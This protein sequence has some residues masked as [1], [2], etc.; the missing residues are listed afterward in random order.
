MPRL[1]RSLLFFSLSFVLLWSTASAASPPKPKPAR[2]YSAPR[3]TGKIMQPSPFPGPGGPPILTIDGDWKLIDVPAGLTVTAQDTSPPVTTS[4]DQHVYVLSGADGVLASPLP[5]TIKN[6]LVPSSDG[7]IGIDDGGDGTAVYMVSQEVAEGIDASEAAGEL[8]PEIAAIAEPLDEDAT[9]SSFGPIP[10]SSLG[11][12]CAPKPESYNKV[13]NLSD[14]TYTKNFTLSGGFS[15]SFSA[16][17][18]IT[19]T[20]N[21]DVAFEVKRKNVLGVCVPYGAR[22]KTLHAYGNATSNG[23]IDLTGTLNY[24]GSFGPWELAK[25]VLYEFWVYPYGIP[26]K[27]GFNLPVTSALS[28]TAT[29]T[30]TVNYNG[31]HVA[32]GT[33]DYTCTLDDC[34]GT[35]TFENTPD[36]SDQEITGGVSGHIKPVPYL[37]VGVRA[38]LY[39][40]S[41]AYAQIGVRGTLLPGGPVGLRRQRLR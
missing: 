12:S 11:G 30:G 39:S 7:E 31:T 3:V 32:T 37:Y 17:G 27:I 9:A 28:L 19:G 16:T 1:R 25:P 35:H 21:A 14:K 23:G 13:I 18:H 22:F 8:T 15:G 34:T 20:V 36:S 10:N 38:Y 2:K 26:V 6:E 24:S 29:V 41:I 5:D 33:F 40:D 4:S